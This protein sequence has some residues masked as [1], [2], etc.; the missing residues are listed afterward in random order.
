MNYEPVDAR[1]L[2]LEMHGGIGNQLLSFVNGMLLALSTKR[3]M[4]FRP[5]GFMTM[6]HYNSLELYDSPVKWMTTDFVI[7]HGIPLPLSD[8]IKTMT[9]DYWTKGSI[10]AVMCSSSLDMLGGSH[11]IVHLRSA[12]QDVHLL[13]ANPQYKFRDAFRGLEFFFLSHFLWTGAWELDTAVRAETHPRP[14]SWDGERSLRAL[15]ADIRASGAS[16]VVGVHVRVAW[17]EYVDS[18]HYP[19]ALPASPAAWPRCADPPA[20][21]AP[22]AWAAGGFC[23]SFSLDSILTCFLGPLANLTRPPPSAQRPLVILWATDDD[24]LSRPL[25]DALAALPAARLV[26]P[27]S[28]PCVVVCFES[29]C[30]FLL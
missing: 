10:E 17:F 19:D 12:A 7:G 8:P 24:D 26:R 2:V 5:T 1:W 4:V 25:F 23:Y 9:L 13:Q 21:P 28:V 6:A 20:H 3:I 22:S 15:I 30:C 11:D 27:A 29:L 16:A 18:F 14:A